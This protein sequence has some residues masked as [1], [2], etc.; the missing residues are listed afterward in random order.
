MVGTILFLGTVSISAP[1]GRECA[2]LVFYRSEGAHPGTS[3]RYK[4][5]SGKSLFA[6]RPLPEILGF[7]PANGVPDESSDILQFELL[8]DVG[9]VNVDGLGAQM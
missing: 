1:F 4:I 3:P 6:R 9:P 5:L 7:D 2:Y 8:L